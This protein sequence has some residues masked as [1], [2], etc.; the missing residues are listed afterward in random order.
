MA[1]KD[2][3][4]GATVGVAVGGVPGGSNPATLQSY[5]DTLSSYIPRVDQFYIPEWL[6]VQFLT[7][8]LICFTPLISYGSTVISL[9]RS[10]T[11]LGFSIDIC[12][13]MLIASLLRVSYYIITPYDTTLLRQSLVMISIQLVL[14]HTSLK[15]RPEEYKYDKLQDVESFACLFQDAWNEFNCEQETSSMGNTTSDSTADI[16]TVTLKRISRLILQTILIFVYK[17]LKFFDP[18]FKRFQSFWQW[19]NTKNYWRFLAV[20]AS[21]QLCLTVF[22][23]KIMNWDDLAQWL[24]SFIGSLGLLVESTLPLPQISILYKLKSVQGFKLILLVSWLCGDTLKLTYLMFGATNISVLFVIFALLQMGLDFYIGGQYIYYKYYYKSRTLT[25]ND[26]DFDIEL[27]DLSIH[28]KP[29]RNT[30]TSFQD[31]NVIQSEN[32]EDTPGF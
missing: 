20:F 19:N 7:K 25:N 3:V 5:A 31:Q 2:L 27:N 8:N 26:S 13:T 12:A 18:S 9:E 29:R 6:T 1:E 11:A 14:L 24:G 10:R 28:S 22:I 4:A 16:A 17:T 21:L 23:A 32:R 15:Y 30:V